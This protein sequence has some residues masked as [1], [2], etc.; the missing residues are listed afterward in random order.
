MA[1]VIAAGHVHNTRAL[2]E[3]GARLSFLGTS[4]REQ[5]VIAITEIPDKAAMSVALTGMGAGMACLSESQRER[6]FLAADGIVNEWARTRALAGLAVGLAFLDEQ[7]ARAGY[8]GRRHWRRVGKGTHVVS[9][10]GEHGSHDGG[11]A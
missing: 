3:L 4:Q 9:T 7:Q 6:L 11:T 5:V 10:R 1:A 2:A 8:R